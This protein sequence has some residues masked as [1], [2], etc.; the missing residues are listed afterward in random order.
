MRIAIHQPNFF[1]WYPFFQ[2]ISSV[3]KFVILNHCQFEKNGY[4]NRFNFNDN[5]YTMS[6]KKGLEPIKDKIYLNPKNDWDRIKN[7]LPEYKSI[8]NEFDDCIFDVLEKTNIFIINRLCEMLNITTEI[9][10]DYPTELKSTHRLIDICNHYGGT[11]YLSGIGAKDYLDEK[12]FKENNINISYQEDMGLK[13]T[14]E[15]L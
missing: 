15:V 5:W 14:L 1:P 9:V 12:L 7:R 13:H 4:Q 8:L 6:V 2:K 11:E 10:T 3:D